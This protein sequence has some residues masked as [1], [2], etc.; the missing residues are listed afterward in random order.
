ML[1]KYSDSDGVDIFFGVRNRG[2]VRRAIGVECRVFPRT[3][4]SDNSTDAFGG[5]IAK[6]WYDADDNACGIQLYYPAAEFYF[7]EK[8]FLGVGLGEAELF[9]SDQGVAFDCEDDNTGISIKGGAVRF[10]APN[11]DELGNAAIIE[12]VYVE[13]PRL[14]H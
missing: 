10:Y 12:A 8:Q 7:S 5:S 11:A 4:F 14:E 1:F 3:E 6:V 13:I 9:L 2:D